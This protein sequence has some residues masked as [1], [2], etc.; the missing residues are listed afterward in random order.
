MTAR[1][2]EEDLLQVFAEPYNTLILDREGFKCPVPDIPEFSLKDHMNAWVDRK[3]FIHNLGHATAAYKGYSAHPDARFIYEVLEDPG[4]WLFTREVMMESSRI[5]MAGYPGEFTH[6]SLNGHVE[7]LLA[8]F[9]NRN[10]G[11]TVFRVGC[12]LKR[13]LGREDRFMGAIRLAEKHRMSAKSIIRAMAL[14]FNFKAVD[15]QANMLPGD[16]EFHSSV[17]TDLDDVLSD[18]CGLQI[19]TDNE[20]V[21]SLKAYIFEAMKK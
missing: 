6:D 14:G 1:D 4:V 19:P 13:K 12:D 20:I 9:K 10:L 16:E 8:R 18:V 5:L 21:H 3:A 11:D 15:E 2:L 17:R 7:D